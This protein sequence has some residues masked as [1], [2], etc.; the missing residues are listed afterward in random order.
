[1]KKEDSMAAAA[2]TS[3]ARRRNPSDTAK[4][5][6]HLIP[7]KRFADE[8][9]G[10]TIKGYSDLDLLKYAG[11][12]GKNVLLSGPTGPGK[13]SLILAYA[14]AN[15]IPLV[16]LA[17]NGAIEPDAAFGGPVQD[18]VKKVI[19]FQE[20]DAI[21]VIRGGGLLYF[22]EIN[23]MPPKISA[24]FHGLLDKR[25]QVTL[26]AKGNEL[27][28]AHPNLQ[29]VAAYNPEYIGTR[30]LNPAFK[31]R[32]SIKIQFDYDRKVEEQ[33]LQTTTI[34]DVAEQLR[35]RHEAGD[36]DTPVSTNMLQE[37]EEFCI[38]L[39]YEFA[40]ENFLNAFNVDERS[41]V[42]DVM[43]LHSTGIRSEITA[44]LEQYE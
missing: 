8:Y 29:I 24:V 37:F 16:T 21:K 26:L 20:S 44:L 13:T 23:F 5:L 30:P 4:E 18:P 3:T 33:L 1:M 34:I 32:F 10:R 41:A 39:G 36:I 2:T 19:Y 43:E 35:S 6:A 22:D 25:R 17:C 15:K 9:I 28:K 12:A 38:D 11:S 31:N 14:A 42:R 40:V 27:I 7:E